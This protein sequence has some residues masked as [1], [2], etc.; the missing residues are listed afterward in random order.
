MILCKFLDLQHKY[1]NT[2]I[3]NGIKFNIPNLQNMKLT[4]AKW[5]ELNLHLPFDSTVS[6]S[7]I[8]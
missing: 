7:T 6:M 1:K 4:I 2:I 3:R 5:Y 8:C